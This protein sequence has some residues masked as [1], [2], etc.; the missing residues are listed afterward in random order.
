MSSKP[1][2]YFCGQDFQGHSG[3]TLGMMCPGDSVARLALA[4]PG[5]QL[6]CGF[7]AGW[8][9]S[10]SEVLG[11]LQRLFPAVGQQ[12]PGLEDA[13]PLSG[14]RL[15]RLAGG[16]VGLSLSAGSYLFLLPLSAACNGIETME[17]SSHFPLER[18]TG[19]A[20]PWDVLPASCQHLSQ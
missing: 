19:T 18:E 5:P 7:A 1:R 4:C 20:I 10:H 6:C 16:E 13:S 11:W 12:E 8:W 14:D 15:A 2:G 17:L 3:V 9:Q